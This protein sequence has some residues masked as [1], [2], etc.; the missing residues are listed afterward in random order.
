MMTRNWETRGEFAQAHASA[1]A[2]FEA[3]P[4]R[5][6]PRPFSPYGAHFFRVVPSA[7]SPEALYTSSVAERSA[8]ITF[9]DV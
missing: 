3:R 4:H 7:G 9:R 8:I 2:S 1:S 5:K 6:S